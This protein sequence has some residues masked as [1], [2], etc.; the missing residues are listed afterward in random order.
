ML[1]AG[2]MERDAAL[3][4][5]LVTLSGFSNDGRLDDDVRRGNESRAV[6]HHVG[7]AL[8]T[9]EN[10][11]MACSH[12]R[13]EEIAHH[14]ASSLCPGFAGARTRKNTDSMSLSAQCVSTAL[15]TP[16]GSPFPPTFPASPPSLSFNLCSSLTRSN[17]S[18]YH[19]SPTST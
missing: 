2:E 5:A 15:S 13:T 9:G 17:N 4:E 19:L 18:G 12:V 6:H 11:F 16:P 10:A 3:V 7:V 1:P 14:E 8:Q